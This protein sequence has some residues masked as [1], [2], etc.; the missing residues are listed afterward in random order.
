M[1]GPS[2]PMSC[3]YMRMHA[4]VRS[5]VS[6][7][8]MC[9][10]VRIRACLC[11]Y[12]CVCVCVCVRAYVWA[13][14]AYVCVCVYGCIHTCVRACVSVVF[15][16]LGKPWFHV[17]SKSGNLRNWVLMSILFCCPGPPGGLWPAGKWCMQLVCRWSG[18]NCFKTEVCLN[19]Q[20]RAWKPPSF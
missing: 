7:V 15:K 14:V 4:R 16:D 6:C 3:T 10:C 19:L 17:S 5:Y 12:V 13:C 18:S 11:A 1:R 9:A 20:G 8:H 2:C